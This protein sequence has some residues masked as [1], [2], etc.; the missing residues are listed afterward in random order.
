M[1]DGSPKR[2]KLV[3]VSQTQ[4]LAVSVTCNNDVAVTTDVAVATDVAEAAGERERLMVEA[5]LSFPF[6]SKVSP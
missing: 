5:N 1:Y 3:Q 4:M 2:V 6:R